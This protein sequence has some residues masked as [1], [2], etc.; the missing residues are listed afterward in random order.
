MVD[1]KLKSYD[2]TRIQKAWLG[3]MAGIYI[4][5]IEGNS[6]LYHHKQYLGTIKTLGNEVA[7]QATFS[8][9]G[10]NFIRSSCIS[11]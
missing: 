8:H 7:G 3:F 6:I 4:F 10:D 5:L 2:N 11:K 9:Q 1:L